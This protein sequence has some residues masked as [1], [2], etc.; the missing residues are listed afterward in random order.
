MTFDAEPGASSMASTL[1]AH[2]HHMRR[3]LLSSSPPPP[4]MPS[5][6]P[7]VTT[8]A[9][10]KDVCYDGYGQAYYCRSAG[11]RWWSYF[12]LV[13]GICF[14][15]F[16]FIL[17]YIRRRRLQAFLA[18]Q[19]NVGVAGGQPGYP[20]PQYPMQQYPPGQ[21]P[22]GQYPQEGYPQYPDQQQAPNPYPPSQGE[23]N[24]QY[25]NQQPP[26]QQPQQGY[27]A[28]APPEFSQATVSHL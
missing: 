12:V 10:S 14:L 25:P 7:S 24:Q 26:H 23:Q 5:S 22:P 18:A 15:V 16:F 1:H 13:C 21:Y 28:P 11:W 6:V 2:L 9:V 27:P 8:D 20:Y 19:Q 17:M 4:P 3:S